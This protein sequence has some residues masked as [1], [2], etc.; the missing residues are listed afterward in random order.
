M[1]ATK[2]SK[3]KIAANAKYTKEHY[4]KICFTLRAEDYDKIDD[5]CKAHGISKVKFV[6]AA[7]HYVHDNNIN[8]N[9]V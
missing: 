1:A 4:K 9:I 8:I 6:T 7:L 3:A 5:Y 2:S